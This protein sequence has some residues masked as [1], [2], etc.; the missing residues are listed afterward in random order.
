MFKNPFSFD[1]RIRRTEYGLTILCNTIV[2]LIMDAL[3]INGGN[4]TAVLTLLY[5]PMLWFGLAQGAKRCH[6]LGNS[7]WWQLIPFYGLW[8]LF[9]D[10]QAGP[11]EYGE[12]PK[13]IQRIGNSIFDNSVTSEYSSKANENSTAN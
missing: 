3:I 12:N 10:G 6:D 2:T 13:G 4:D 8:M 1:G 9:Q 5:I 11:N 7:G